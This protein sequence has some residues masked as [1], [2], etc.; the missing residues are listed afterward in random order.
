VI[1]RTLLA[2]GDSLTYGARC[3]G[4]GW[5]DLLPDALMPGMAT[6]VLN[7][8]VCGETTWQILQRAPAAV[9]ELAALPGDRVM[10]LWAGTNDSKGPT[11]PQTWV[12]S[13]QQI[14]HWPARYRI[15]VLLLTLPPVVPGSMHC[16][17]AASVE[18]IASVNDGIRKMA[19]HP[20]RALVEVADLGPE[21]LIDG[22]HL[23][24]EGHAIVA[25]RVAKALRDGWAR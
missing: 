16:Y 25:E 15:P 18:W 10:T 11:H 13:Y 5:C 7:R 23:N 21:H 3:E 1:Y 9:R 14:L 20:G 22:V 4:D 17:T 12:R 19:D 8:G 2:L 6:A 24:R